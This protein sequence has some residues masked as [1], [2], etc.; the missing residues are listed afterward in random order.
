MV[1][2]IAEFAQ[3]YSN[4]DIDGCGFE[5]INSKAL[6]NSWVN[7]EK[8]H[9]SEVFALFITGEKNIFK[10]S[11]INFPKELQREDL[12]LT[13]DYPEDLIVC[14]YIFNNLIKHNDPYDLFNLVKYLDANPFLKNL[15]KPY[16]EKG[17]Q[18]MY[19]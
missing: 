13:V 19:L 3:S 14:R 16:F 7:G 11:Q 15:I 9:R 8:K 6:K 10:I 5:I 12:Y 2:I 18:T 17:Y 1:K 4:D